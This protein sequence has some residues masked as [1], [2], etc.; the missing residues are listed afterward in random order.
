[1]RGG[2]PPDDFVQSWKYKLF[3][4]CAGVIL[5]RMGSLCHL[6]PFPRMR[7]G[8][9]GFMTAEISRANFSP[10]ARG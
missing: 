3:P 1:M 2:D 10:H 7:G 5:S 6:R 8:D 4:A 9:P